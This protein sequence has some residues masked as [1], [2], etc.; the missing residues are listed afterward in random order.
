[1]YLQCHMMR[2]ALQYITCPAYICHII[3]MYVTLSGRAARTH[4]VTL[5]V[6][7]SHTQYAYHHAACIQPLRNIIDIIDIINI[8]YHQCHYLHIYT[9]KNNSFDVGRAAPAHSITLALYRIFA[10]HPYGISD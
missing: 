2:R 8:Q 3:Y 6:I 7:R 10:A 1:M 5:A 4:S 9:T